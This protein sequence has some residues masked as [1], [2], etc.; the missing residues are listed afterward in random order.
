M[1]S[2]YDPT[3][4]PGESNRPQRRLDRGKAT[5]YRA[6]HVVARVALRPLVLLALMSQPIA[7]AA[8]AVLI[9]SSPSAR[10]MLSQA[11]T[12]VVLKFN[13][14]LEPAF[15]SLSV[16]SADGFQVD[17]QDVTVGPED[18]RRL[19]VGLPRL[20]AGVY[21]VH[22]R[23]LSCGRPRGGLELPVHRQGPAPA[24]EPSLTT[25]GS[26][27]TLCSMLRLPATIVAA[28]VLALALGAPAW[29]HT[30]AS[31][32][33]VAAALALI[34]PEPPPPVLAAAPEVPGLPW[35]A[36]LGVLG[37]VGVA[38]RRPRRA[39]VFAVVLILAVFA[40]EDG[41]HS[42][43]HAGDQHHAAT[44]LVASASAH[45]SATSV[46]IGSNHDVVFLTAGHA[47][48]RA[49]SAP[50]SRPFCPDQGRAPPSASA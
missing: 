47:L 36:L 45:L 23:V 49:G 44:C 50:V 21:T 31:V 1:A 25:A 15:S 48:E 32:P 18:R 2:D 29:A 46:D 6:R 41:L 11:P 3:A 39:L 16:W 26:L 7:S 17:D 22:F 34:A 38:W 27:V 33:D 10:A 19:S 24:E 28:V 9:S 14:R 4:V 35:P 5:G 40:F 13:E 37:A 8:H 30:A 12:R 20:E 42:V 43:H